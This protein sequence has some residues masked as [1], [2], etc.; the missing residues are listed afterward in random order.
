[1]KAKSI[2]S[3]VTLLI[4]SITL[5][6]NSHGIE[7]P[8]VKSG[9]PKETQREE[10]SKQVQDLKKENDKYKNDEVE[11]KN[12]YETKLQAEKQRA[13][14]LFNE[15]IDLKFRAQTAGEILKLK[16]TEAEAEKQKATEKAKEASEL[17][18]KALTANEVLKLKEAELQDRIQKES[19]LEAELKKVYTKIPRH[20]LKKYGIAIGPESQILDRV[21]VALSCLIFSIFLSVI[22]LAISHSH[23]KG[24]FILWLNQKVWGKRL[25]ST[26]SQ[27]GIAFF[28]IYE[29]AVNIPT[30]MII[31]EKLLNWIA[32]GN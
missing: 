28:C 29:I 1:M 19:A 13:D 32:K 30:V 16:E 15:V 9:D 11:L 12:E 18:I 27:Y 20:V 25:V 26:I 10:L 17:Q 6:I 21:K 2:K 4:C 5:Q 7:W 24:D 22:L 14:G 3:V 8:W 31:V 23:R